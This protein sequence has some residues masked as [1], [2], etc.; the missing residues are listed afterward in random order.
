MRCLKTEEIQLGLH[1]VKD[2]FG[3]GDRFKTAFDYCKAEL[4]THSS[5][6][7]AF[8]LSFTNV[9]TSFIL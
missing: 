7:D 4:E 2:Y 8:I 9:G 1:F 5:T 6:I 3:E